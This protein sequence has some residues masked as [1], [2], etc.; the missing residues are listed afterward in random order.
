[1]YT[2]DTNTIIYYLRDDPNAVALLDDI[3]SERVRIYVSTVTEIELFGYP[4]LTLAETQKIN[5][6]LTSISTISLDS[7]IARTAGFFRR[8]YGLK[9]PDSAIAATALLTGSTLVTR[10][11]KDFEKIPNLSIKKI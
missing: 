1:M 3:L 7:N 9:L 11:I 2:L 4:D 8:L 6:I 10:N 5:E